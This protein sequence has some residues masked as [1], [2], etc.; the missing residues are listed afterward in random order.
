[1]LLK[2]QEMLVEINPEDVQM[3][4]N[5][6]LSRLEKAGMSPPH[7][8]VI[9]CNC[10]DHNWEPELSEEQISALFKAAS[11][12]A[13]TGLPDDV[14]VFGL[15]SIE[16]AAKKVA[17]WPQWKTDNIKNVFSEPEINVPG[18]YVISNEDFDKLAEDLG[19]TFCIDCGVETKP[20]RSSA[21]CKECWN[22]KV[23]G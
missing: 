12:A 9:N 19:V 20:G 5:Q 16:N 23:G 10:Y 3:A 8:K 6:I 15:E 21:R 2:I 4:A 13:N 18:H 14:E 1:M 22:D 11:I 7:T 17:E